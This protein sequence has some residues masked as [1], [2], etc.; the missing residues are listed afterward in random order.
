MAGQQQP[1]WHH[2]SFR[3]MIGSVLTGVAFVDHVLRR[4]LIDALKDR[5]WTHLEAERASEYAGE[6]YQRAGG[7]WEVWCGQAADDPDYYRV[8]RHGSDAS[9]YKAMLE[10][11]AR[12]VARALNELEGHD[13]D[14]TGTR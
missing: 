12:D 9:V 8:A 10:G 2:G 6:F 14:A 11:R 3:R 4:S 7:T 5:G 1:R 13:S